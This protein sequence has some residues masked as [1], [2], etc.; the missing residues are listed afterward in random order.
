[1]VSMSFFPLAVSPSK[2]SLSSL[3]I[4]MTSILNAVPG[5][6]LTSTSLSSLSGVF[7]CFFCFLFFFHVGHASL[8]PHLVCLSAFVSVHEADLPCSPALARPP[9]AA[10]FWGARWRGDPRARR[11][12]SALR[13]GSVPSCCRRASAAAGTS[14]GRVGPWAEWP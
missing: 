12:A 1:M 10:G 8:R 4:L 14:A 11:P 13:E 5:R 2:L 6:L 3:G 7:S 9:C